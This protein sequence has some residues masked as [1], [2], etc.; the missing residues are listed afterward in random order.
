MKTLLAILLLFPA[1]ANAQTFWPRVQADLVCTSQ[2]S[3]NFISNRVAS[4]V[5]TNTVRGV[6]DASFR[7][8]NEG[9][10]IR[11][12]VLLEFADYTRTSNIWAQV[13][14]SKPANTTGRV[15]LYCLPDDG[16]VRDWQGADCDTRAR[17]KEVVW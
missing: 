17:R 12:H 16:T 11:V 5:G 3:A 10:I 2:A 7:Q 15:L 13:T 1:L 9:S 6:R 14:T 4:A 8:L